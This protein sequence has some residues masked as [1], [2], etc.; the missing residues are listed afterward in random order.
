MLPH[1]FILYGTDAHAVQEIPPDD[2]ALHAATLVQQGWCPL[3]TVN[4]HD[5]ELH[6]VH[7]Y[8]GAFVPQTRETVMKTF[9]IYERHIEQAHG[10]YPQAAN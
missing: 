10:I 4:S 6:I 7:I 9:D 8:V 2:V 3:H 5:P 1:M